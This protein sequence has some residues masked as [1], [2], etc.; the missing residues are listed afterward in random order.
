MTESAVVF[1]T[2]QP[3]NVAGRD[4]G[5][6]HL[7]ILVRDAEINAFLPAQGFPQTLP[8]DED[9]ERLINKSLKDSVGF[10]KIGYPDKY[11]RMQATAVSA[12]LRA[13][14]IL[15]GGKPKDESIENLKDILPMLA[16]LFEKEQEIIAVKTIACIAEK[17][18]IKAEKLTKTM[19]P[20]GK[21]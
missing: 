1:T 18:T 10:A 8:F 21:S 7:L 5:S 17:A 14:G 13:V 12:G 2:I 19:M 9:W 20:W 3:G 6:D 11:Q 16:T 4:L 15:L